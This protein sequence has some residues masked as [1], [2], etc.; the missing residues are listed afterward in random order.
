M[1]SVF[2]IDVE[3][4]FHILDV[5][6][7]P[8][9]GQWDSLP[10]SVEKNFR[11]LLTI[12]REAEVRTTCFFLGWIARRYPHLVAEAIAGGHEIASHG[13]AH[14]LVH[15]MTE[16][17][18]YDDI[19]RA[20]GI[21]EDVG[22]KTVI[23]YRAPGF[24]ISSKSPWYFTKVAEA[25]YQYDSSIFP[26]LHEHG[27]VLKTP[28]GPHV[29]QTGFGSLHEFPISTVTV[30]GVPVSVFGGGYL[31]LT[32][33]PMI[34]HM[35]WEVLRSGRPAVFYIHP[36]EIAPSRMQL[37]MSPRRRFKSYVNVAS[38]EKKLRRILSLFQFTT[39]AAH[40]AE[41]R[42]SS[43]AASAAPLTITAGGPT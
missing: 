8:P 9:L 23:G 29:I 15:K 35:T 18:F 42:Q 19:I 33:L 30:M 27:E 17:E 34:E 24:S 31:R 21:L 38:T 14:Q 39:F 20:K 3:D 13:Y 25:G 37:P 2:T 28:Y 32:P 12:F 16:A 41:S 26:S 4:W 7:T 10:S 22:G 1:K 36:R 5:P 6:S 11:K 43:L 40:L